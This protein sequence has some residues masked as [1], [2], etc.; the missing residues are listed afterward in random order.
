MFVVKIKCVIVCV[1]QNSASPKISTI[2]LLGFLFI[3]TDFQGRW[4]GRVDQIFLPGEELRG[5]GDWS[6]MIAYI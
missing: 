5:T 6:E 2:K 1:V 3:F 4:R